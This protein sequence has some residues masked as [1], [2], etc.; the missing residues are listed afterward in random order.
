M[1]LIKELADIVRGQRDGPEQPV[2]PSQIHHLLTKGSQPSSSYSLGLPNSALVRR[3]LCPGPCILSAL[4]WPSS[5]GGAQG[6][7]GLPSRH[8]SMGPWNSLPE[9]LPWT[10]FRACTGFCSKTIPP[11]VDGAI[12]VL[13]IFPTIDQRVIVHT[14][15]EWSSAMWL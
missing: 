10:T 2:L 5:C 8:L 15:C 14:A 9:W 12:S 4:F 13:T 3:R 6:V 11:R 7:Q 1:E